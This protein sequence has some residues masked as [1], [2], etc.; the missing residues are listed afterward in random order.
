VRVIMPLAFAALALSTHAVAGEH[1]RDYL[2]F[3]AS[4]EADCVMLQGEMRQLKNTHPER[5]IEA[6]IYRYM[7][8]IQQPGRR[9]EIVPPGGKPL[10]LGCTRITGGAAQ[11]W[12]ISKAQFV[13]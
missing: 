4:Y 5:A 13:R 6:Y 3:A 12:E 10:N 1:A 2:K 7:G 11:D 8:E 9:V